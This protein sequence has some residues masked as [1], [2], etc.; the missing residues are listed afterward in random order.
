MSFLP[1]LIAV[2]V[3]V[4][5]VAL[6]YRQMDERQREL[7]ARI[8]K[9]EGDIVKRDELIEILWGERADLNRALGNEEG[10][11]FAKL[12]EAK[13]KRQIK[14]ANKDDQPQPEREEPPPADWMPDDE[15]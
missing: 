13:I 14:D 4:G 15:Q 8:A 12:R 11:V 2:I 3:A 9:L 7:L 5:S 1:W 10:T 6:F